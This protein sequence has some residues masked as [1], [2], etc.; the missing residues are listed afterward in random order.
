MARGTPEAPGLMLALDRGGS[1]R[2]LVFRVAAENV[3]EELQILWRREMILGSYEARWVN[4]TVGGRRLRAI[5]FVVNQAHVQYA[6]GLKDDQVA[7]FITTGVGARGTSAEYFQSTVTALHRLGIRDKN[8]DRLQRVVNARIA[9]PLS[10]P[11]RR[12]PWPQ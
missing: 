4:A 3:R 9:T 2:G 11:G 7:H 6:G 12:R 8:I 10:Q 1:C 5:T